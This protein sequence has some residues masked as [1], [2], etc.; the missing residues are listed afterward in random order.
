MASTAAAIPKC[1]AVLQSWQVVFFP[2][3]SFATSPAQFGGG[4]LR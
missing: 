4:D 3:S 1:G 2:A